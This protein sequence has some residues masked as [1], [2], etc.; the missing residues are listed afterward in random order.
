MQHSQQQ[1]PRPD[2]QQHH[3]SKFPQQPR[4]AAQPMQNTSAQGNKGISKCYECGMKGHF[5]KKCPNKQYVSAIGN[6]S[7]PQAQ[8]N[9][10]Y[11]KVNHVTSVEAQ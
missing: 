11:G 6:Q 8:H 9:Y 4:L 5:A 2:M 3:H 1:A 7:W 10:M